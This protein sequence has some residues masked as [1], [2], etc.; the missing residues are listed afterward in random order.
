MSKRK[1]AKVSKQAHSKVAAKAQRASQA[2][3]RSSK[4]RRLRSVAPAPAESS[5]MVHSRPEAAVLEKPATAIP[6]PEKPT[7]AAS[8]DDSQRAMRNNDLTKAFDAFSGMANVGLYPRKLPEITQRYMQLAFEFAQRLAQIKSPFE[9]P[10]V[11][12]ELA[13]KQLAIFQNLVVPTRVR[14]EHQAAGS[15]LPV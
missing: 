14:G 15:S 3:V 9:V 11:F 8:Q 4:P 5:A 7:M 12:A 2:V 6:V 1:P 10:S 13:T